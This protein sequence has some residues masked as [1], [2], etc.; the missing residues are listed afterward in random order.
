MNRLTFWLLAAF[1][2]TV[3]WDVVEF[4]GGSALSRLVGLAAMG[5]AVLTVVARGRFRKINLIVGLAAA[6]TGWTALSL[7][8]TI[9]YPDTLQR[10]MTYVQLLGSV[11][12]VNEFA[13]SRE[14]QQW[15]LVAFCLGEF[16]P[17]ILLLKNFNSGVQSYALRDRFTATGFNADDIGLT[18]VIGMPI[19][20]HLIQSFRGPVRVVA[21]T[22]FALAPLAILLT[23]TRGAFIAGMIAIS[24]VPL[25]LPRQSPR[26]LLLTGVLLVVVAAATSVLV[27]PRTWSRILSIKQEVLGGGS[28]T[29][30]ADIW[31]AG[32]AVFPERPL[33][34]AGAGAYGPA[35][36]PLTGNYRTSP[37]N[38]PLGVLVEQGVIGFVVFAALLMACAVVI[39]RMPSPDRK[40][41]AVLM[42][43]WI[44]GVMSLN[45]EY[46]KVTWLLFGLLATKAVPKRLLHTV[47]SRTEGSRPSVAPSGHRASGPS[48]A[49]I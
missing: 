2:F 41:W 47:G 28:M 1:V 43:C 34:G 19:A 40:L 21:S 4:S 33:L 17:L 15:L 46:R 32:L 25:T 44:V 45:W 13:S 18:L 11:W 31:K 36:G 49:R 16:V 27:P 14:D 6:F 22:F 10:V 23:G 8:W 30:R 29:G 26:A 7:L 35:V 37:H 24:I 39:F 48:I 38:M 9:S 3:P 5:A 42:L 20:W 12:V